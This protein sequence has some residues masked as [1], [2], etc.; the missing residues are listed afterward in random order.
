MIIN[1][2]KLFLSCLAKDLFGLLQSNPFFGGDQIFRCHT[3]FDLLCKISLKLKI[4]VRNDP[5]QFSSFCNR[6]PGNAELRH[7]CIRVR[8]RMF[9]CQGKR[10]CD[11]A[12]FRP[13]YLIHLFGLGFN[14]HIL[15][16][17]AYSSLPCHCNRH[18]M[19]GNCVHPRTHH[20][21]VELDLLCQPCGQIHLI[22]NDL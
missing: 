14:G 13:F 6:H 10:I 20:G 18:P 7:Q 5:H 8:Q 3:A 16:N 17:N 4:P 15:M 11:N 12:I 19:F 21:N 2:R 22:G 1:N 9:R